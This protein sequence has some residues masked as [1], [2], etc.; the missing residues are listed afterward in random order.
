MPDDL[1]HGFDSELVVGLI[2]AVGTE[3]DAVSSLLNER[4]KLA[5]YNVVEIRV[6]KDIIPLLCDVPDSVVDSYERISTLMSAGNEAREKAA[7]NSVLANGIAAAIYSQRSKDAEGNP[8][9]Q[10]KTAFIV[11][12][13]KRPEEV[14]RLR[15][16]YPAG[17]VLIG[18]HSEED[19][20]LKHLRNN[21]GISE[22]GKA[23]ELIRRDGEELKVAHGQRVNR[24]FH[25][26]DFFIRITNNN[27]RLRSDVKRMVEIWFGN[28]FLTPVFD[29]YA[30]F[31]AFSAALRSADLSRQVGAVIARG[32]EVLSAGANECPKAGGGLYWPKRDELGTNIIDSEGGRDYKLGKDS[33]ILEQTRII[34]EIVQRGEREDFDGDQLREL[35]ERSGIRDLTEYGRVVHAEMEALSACARN[36]LSTVGATLY[37]TTFPCHNC[38]KHII[39]AGIKR[40]VYIEPYPKSKALEFHKDSVVMSSEPDDTHEELVGFEPFEGIGPRRFFD[41]FSARLGS[42][43]DLVR[44]D[45]TTGEKREWSIRDARLRIQMKP[46]SY[47]DLELRACE[48]FQDHLDTIKGESND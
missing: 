46:L 16:M 15:M 33:N 8:S 28:P 31:L 17:F 32:K 25:L 10:P 2:G 43:Y 12:S 34:N 22:V 23:E 24:T 44:K 38:A 41:L 7:D 1:S 26:A 40:V 47:L 3:L 14:E 21:L 9:P 20:R 30:M 45:A 4:L 36:G 5:G 42:G 29:E 18:V 37:C 35:L 27:E 19:R 6:S 48:L 11:N 13:L 39:A